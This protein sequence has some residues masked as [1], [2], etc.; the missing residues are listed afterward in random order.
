MDRISR[1]LV[2]RCLVPVVLLMATLAASVLLLPGCSGLGDLAPARSSAVRVRDDLSTTIRAAEDLLASLPEGDLRREA[3]ERDLA[4]T[5]ASR[6]AVNA[7]IQQIDLLVS[8]VTSPTDSLTLGLKAV[9]ESLPE[10]VRAPLLLGGALIVMSMRAGRLKAALVS[11]AKSIEKAKQ[12]DE[13][14]DERFRAHAASIRS[15]QTPTAQRIIDEATK[16]T[17][18]LRFPL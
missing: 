1:R 9:G 17:L 8:E 3:I 2:A 14:F 11:V 18:V 6:E 15:V 16:D 13:A 12:A 7:A 4:S 5:R 10:P